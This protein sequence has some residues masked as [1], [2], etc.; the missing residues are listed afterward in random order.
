M[1]EEA[2][3]YS[4]KFNILV[5]DD[6]Y[7]VANVVRR[8]LVHEGYHVETAKNGRKAMDLLM[9]TQHFDLVI[10]DLQM[11]E[12]DGIEL[13]RQARQCKAYLPVI[14]MTGYV[15]TEDGMECVEAGA[16]NYLVK[17]FRMQSLLRLVREGLKTS[18]MNQL[19][20]QEM[21]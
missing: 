1:E 9:S 16:H 4:P 8:I 13:L 6:D 15:S 14:A 3:A 10:T 18:F 7:H 17:P 21:P 12:M 2:S 20:V 5:V 11:P 19:G